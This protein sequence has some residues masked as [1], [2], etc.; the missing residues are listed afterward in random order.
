MSKGR[1]TESEYHRLLAEAD[2]NGV[3]IRWHKKANVFYVSSAHGKQPNHRVNWTKQGFTCDS[4]QTY[5]VHRAVARR[6]VIQERD[7]YVEQVAPR[8]PQPVAS[9]PLDYGTWEH[10]HFEDC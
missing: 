7:S 8:K 9:E 6:A 1:T 4:C 10:V 2:R 5:C 3:V